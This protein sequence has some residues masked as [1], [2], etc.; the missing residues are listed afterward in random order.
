MYKI[1]KRKSSFDDI[2]KS[3]PKKAFQFNFFKNLNF[4]I[5]QNGMGQKRAKAFK[6]LI[7]KYGA[8][9]I[10][11]NEEINFTLKDNVEENEYLEI[12]KNVKWIVVFENTVIQ[13]WEQIEKALLNKNFFTSF[14]TEYRGSMN[15]A[16]IQL[17]F[18]NSSWLSECF[19]QNILVDYRK[20]EIYPGFL[21]PSKLAPNTKNTNEHESNEL[22]AF[23]VKK[24]KLNDSD[25]ESKKR[26]FKSFCD[27]SENLSSDENS[28]SDD[29]I[30]KEI[31]QIKDVKSFDIN[32][33]T[34]AHSSQESKYTPNKHITDIL[35]ELASIYENTRD[36]FRANSYQKAVIALKRC[37]HPITTKEV[38]LFF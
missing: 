9:I 8:N 10:D 18:I 26:L 38:I 25:N 37:K 16:N 12:Y 31:F 32:L 28:F 21:K 14:I 24:S 20:Y 36:K 6:D 34:C 13:T 27:K 19:K 35:E 2:K 5:L 30:E 29:E 4:Y 23:N 22:V 11:E 3:S 17:R 33:L 7:I 1:T 15:P